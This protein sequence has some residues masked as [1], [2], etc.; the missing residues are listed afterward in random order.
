MAQGLEQVRRLERERDELNRELAEARE[1]LE[2][3]RM[4]N[5][6]EQERLREQIHRSWKHAALERNQLRAG[7]ERTRKERDGLREQLQLTNGLAKQLDVIRAAT[8]SHGVEW[9]DMAGARTTA[10]RVRLMA[11]RIAGLTNE[12]TDLR[13][14]LDATLATRENVTL[15]ADAVRAVIGHLEREK[16]KRDDRYSVGGMDLSGPAVSPDQFV[17]CARR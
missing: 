3:A 6:A 2:A 16:S 4:G 5:I 15:S 8:E 7:L 9:R 10:D 17:A 12:R 14:E 13:A 1:E 11:A